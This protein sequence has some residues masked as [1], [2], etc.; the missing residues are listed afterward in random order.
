MR[1]SALALL[2]CLLSLSL[3]A[4]EDY[5]A[6]GIRFAESEMARFPEAWQLDH[7]SR[8]F[9]GYSQGVGCCA[10]LQVGKYTGN[11]KYFD[12]VEQWADSL[13]ADDGT[14]HLYTPETYNL[15]FINSGK[16]LFEVY[17]QTDDAK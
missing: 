2:L 13:I 5:V 16:V 6:Y 1:K 10:M 4:Q 14:I 8:L 11:K 12:Y 15:D 3:L 7:G 9:F 17:Q